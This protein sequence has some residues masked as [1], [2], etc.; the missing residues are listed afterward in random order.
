M[1]NFKDIVEIWKCN[2]ANYIWKTNWYKSL[3]KFILGDDSISVYDNYFFDYTAKSSNNIALYKSKHFI[4]YSISRFVHDNCYKIFYLINCFYVI[5]NIIN[6]YK[7]K[8]HLMHHDQFLPGIY[9]E[10]DDLIYYCC[11]NELVKFVEFE[12]LPLYVSGHDSEILQLYKWYKENGCDN[13]LTE[14]KRTEKLIQLMQIRN[15]LWV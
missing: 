4:R 3:Q 15:Q 1:I 14:E 12:L 9:Y 7:N 6:N 13:K 8:S 5:D 10:H 11:F 2:D